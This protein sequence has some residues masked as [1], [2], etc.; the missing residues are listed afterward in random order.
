MPADDPRCG[1][2]LSGGGIR[3]AT[4]S[5]GLLRGL[6]SLYLLTRNDYHSTFSGGGY[7]GT[8]FCGL[9][10]PRHNLFPDRADRR[11]RLLERV[12]PGK[13]HGQR[14]G[15]LRGM[16]E[17]VA[18][19]YARSLVETHRGGHTEIASVRWGG[20]RDR[21]TGLR[22]RHQRQQREARRKVAAQAA[23]A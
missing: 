4:F 22:A 5:L 6:S 15:A 9:V 7:T 11:L 1:L 14:S 8:F 13:G 21:G 12:E 2:A 17:P 20:C 19:G 3:S 23:A 18:L 16:M 10:S